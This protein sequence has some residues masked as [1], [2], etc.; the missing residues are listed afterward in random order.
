MGW[1]GNR[2]WLD[3]NNLLGSKL[4]EMAS[5]KNS[6]NGGF[7]VCPFYYFLLLFIN[8]INSIHFIHYYFFLTIPSINYPMHQ[9]HEY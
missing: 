1:S 5:K 7:N 3:I 2:I 4:G 8:Y 9:K 6:K